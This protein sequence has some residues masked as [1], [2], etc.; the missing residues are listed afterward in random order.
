MKTKLAV[1]PVYNARSQV[2][3]VPLRLAI[4]LA[5]SQT[6]NLVPLSN[7]ILS[8]FRINNTTINNSLASSESTLPTRNTLGNFVSLKQAHKSSL[9]NIRVSIRVSSG[10]DFPS[11]LLAL[12]GFA[13]LLLDKIRSRLVDQGVV[14]VVTRVVS[15][16]VGRH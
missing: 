8:S 4:L 16:V 13:L 9:P 6:S 7:K 5:D 1:Y 2:H 15:I 14:V 10:T 3:Q 11:T 12:L